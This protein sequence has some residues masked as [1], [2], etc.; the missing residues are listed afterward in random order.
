MTL[1]GPGFTAI[2]NAPSAPVSVL[3]RI[4]R[5]RCC[6]ASADGLPQRLPPSTFDAAHGRH[7]QDRV[8]DDDADHHDE[9]DHGQQ[10]ERL[11]LDQVQQAQAQHAADQR[12]RHGQQHDQA[13]AQ[14]AEHHRH[15]QQQHDEGHGEYA[16]I[17]LR[18]WLRLSALPASR[19]EPSGGS[20]RAQGAAAPACRCL[21]STFSS[22]SVAGGSMVSVT[23]RRW[24]R[25]R[26]PGGPERRRQLHQVAER[27]G[28]ARR[29]HQ[30]RIGEFLRR[31]ALVGAQD[32]RQP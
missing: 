8:I 29:R 7:Q 17:V 15:E 9:A 27:H 21:C 3:A 32:D 18:V 23:V 11:K 4:A 26:I 22:D 16:A 30:R 5:R 20:W 1:P 14:R 12:E 2:G 25:R 19:S 28:E 6:S 10:I 24:L 31:L 13:V